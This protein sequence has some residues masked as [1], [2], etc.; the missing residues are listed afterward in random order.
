MRMRWA[1]GNNLSCLANA[2]MRERCSVNREMDAG[3]STYRG[4][5]GCVDTKGEK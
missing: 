3:I 1:E 2:S 4:Q 5:V